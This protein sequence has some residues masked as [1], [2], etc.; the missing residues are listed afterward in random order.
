[1]TPY[2]SPRGDS[3]RRGADP[4]RRYEVP[5]VSL[6]T[7]TMAQFDLHEI[8]FPRSTIPRLPSSAAARGARS[9]STRTATSWSRSATATSSSSSCSPATSR[10]STSPATTPKTI[11]V[12]GPGEFTG[13]VSHLTGAP[14]I[15]TRGRARR[16]RGL[17]RSRATLLQADHQPVPGARRHHPAGVHRAAAAAARVGHLH[18]LRVI[19]SRYSHGHLPHPRLPG[20]EPRALHLAR[21]R[22]R[23][24]RSTQLLERFGVTEAETP[25]VACGRKLLLRNPSN[26]ELAEAI[27]IRRPLEQHGLRPGRRRR[28]SGRA[29]GGGLRRVG[30]AWTRWCSSAPRP[31]A[32]RAAA[33]AS[34][35]TSASRPGI[36]GGELA[37]RAVLQASKFGARLSVPTPVTPDVRRRATRSARST[38]GE[39][40]RRQ[41]PA[42]R[43]RRRVPAARGRGLRAVRGLRRLLRRDAE[44][45]AAVPRARTSWSSAAA[46]PPGRRPCSSPRHARKVYLL[47]PRRRPCKSMSELSGAAASSRRR[48]SR[49][50][51]TPT[52]ERMLGDGSSTAVEVVD[53]KTG[54]RRGVEHRRRCSASS[55]P[56]RAPTGCRARSRP[57]RA[58]SS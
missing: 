49:C 28:R 42:D 20:Q 29:R 51:S 25:V 55:A 22:G 7:G 57:T 17:R 3:P 54:E 41:V 12:H 19:G 50:C 35:T 6:Q 26:R 46:T 37:E 38:S 23:S 9:R 8:A 43:D 10:S 24:A 13:D 2:F 56:S 15:V 14:S 30:R 58:G 52:C 36:T 16:V 48:T 40:R 5:L 44:R 47:R 32:R 11:A 53:R 39:T 1:M 4:R 18:G 27:G 45:G 34:R 33:C 21:P 31:A